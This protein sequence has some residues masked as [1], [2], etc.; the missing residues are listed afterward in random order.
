[1]SSEICPI[2]SR[3]LSMAVLAAAGICWSSPRPVG[4][5]DDPT[6]ASAN[7]LIAP[8]VRV[9]MSAAIGS[10][11]WRP[12][13]LGR[14]SAVS[15]RVRASTRTWISTVRR[16]AAACRSRPSGPVHWARPGS[17]ERDSPACSTA[18]SADSEP[19]ACPRAVRSQAA[20]SS[21][22]QGD[23]IPPAISPSTS[24]TSSARWATDRRAALTWFG[25]AIR[26]FTI[27]A[28]AA[29]IRVS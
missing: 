18:V 27:T 29:P 14:S 6:S 11:T 15:R 12:P 19:A 26:K 10:G 7:A 9:S 20:A 28:T 23:A 16:V 22:R 5:R 2:R 13:L 1:M 17:S 4:C 25:G 21:R 24:I 3:A 8:A